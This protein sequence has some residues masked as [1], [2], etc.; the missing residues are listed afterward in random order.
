M[1]QYALGYAWTVDE[2]FM[3][4]KSPNLKI[5]CIS[6]QRLY[7][8]NHKKQLCYKVFRECCKIII[9]DIIENDV[10]FQLPVGSRKTSLFMHTYRETEFEYARKNGKFEE[11]DFYESNFTA[12]Q[13]QLC[14]YGHKNIPIKKQVYVGT[15]LKQKITDYTNSGKVYFRKTIKTIKDYFESVYELFPQ[16][17]QQD[18]RKILNFGWKALYLINSY[19]GDVLIKDYSFWMYIGFLHS[20]SLTHF[21]YYKKKL[22]NKIRIMF[23]RKKIQWDGYYYFSVSEEKYQ[24]YINSKKKRGRPRKHFNFGK[25]NFYKLWDECSLANSGQKYFFKVPYP[26]DMGFTFTNPDFN[27]GEAEFILERDTLKFK[28]ILTSTNEYEFI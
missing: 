26:I 20:N 18:I 25:V 21:E 27:S 16:I 23:N 7:G 11:I 5:D 17:P 28:D 10:E 9:N 3:N 8:D 4:F 12:N 19:G 6:L 14:M 15:N 2:L 22:R 24:E 13:I 1:R